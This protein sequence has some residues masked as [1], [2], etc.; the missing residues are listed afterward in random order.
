MRAPGPADM[1]RERTDIHHV[2]GLSENC[3][4]GLEQAVVYRSAARELF[5][6]E[7]HAL[8]ERDVIVRQTRKERHAGWRREPRFKDRLA[9]IAPAT[10]RARRGEKC[11]DAVQPQMGGV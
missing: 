2:A 11:V 7:V 9:P 10:P 5:A 3:R 4:A 1:R 6:A 8:D